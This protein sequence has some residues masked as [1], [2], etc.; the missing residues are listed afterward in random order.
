MVLNPIDTTAL[1]SSAAGQ[2]FY[3]VLFVEPRMSP[4]LQGRSRMAL[5]E[6]GQRVDAG[7]AALRNFIMVK[8]WTPTGIA[9]LRRPRRRSS[10]RKALVYSRV[11]APEWQVQVNAPRVVRCWWVS[12]AH[13]H[14]VCRIRKGLLNSDYVLLPSTLSVI[15]NSP[16]V[17]RVLDVARSHIFARVGRAARRTMVLLI[18]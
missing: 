13:N 5:N 6:L 16:M 4:W 1:T 10:G 12:T 9:L 3:R 15:V 18:V 2:Q 14:P 8:R 7:R 17:P 11:L